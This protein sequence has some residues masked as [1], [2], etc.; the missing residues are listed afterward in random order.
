MKCGSTDLVD[1]SL[2]KPQSEEP[3]K[4]IS[5]LAARFIH[6]GREWANAHSREQGGVSLSSDEFR[7][8]MSSTRPV[9]ERAE[10]EIKELIA[11]AR[12]TNILDDVLRL[13]QRK[14]EKGALYL[15]DAYL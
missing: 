7:R 4:D 11:E 1:S 14:G 15:I 5:D 8:L 3:S 2:P 9:K 6:A 12:T 13:L 10:K